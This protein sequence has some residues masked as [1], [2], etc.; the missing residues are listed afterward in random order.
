[1]LK[2]YLLAPEL[3]ECSKLDAGS[4]R[5]LL[6]LLEGIATADTFLIP[7]EDLL[8][9]IEDV[10]RI[11]A[12]MAPSVKERLLSD[13][14]ESRGG[15][16]GMDS[17]TSAR[18]ALKRLQRVNTANP[19][20]TV[21]CASELEACLLRRHL[22]TESTCALLGE[23]LKARASEPQGVELHTLPNEAAID[24]L[25]GKF[26]AR[27]EQLVIFDPYIGV[28]VLRSSAERR[29]LEIAMTKLLALASVRAHSARH[30][31]RVVVVLDRSKLNES[32]NRAKSKGGVGEFEDFLND[33]VSKCRATVASMAPASG[34]SSIGIEVSIR[35]A[36]RFQ[37]RGL[38]SSGR[39]W[40]IDH[41]LDDMGELLTALRQI[42]PTKCAARPYTTMCV[43][44]KQK[45]LQGIWTDSRTHD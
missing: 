13:L 33:S 43:E 18:S 23:V 15:I 22:S 27:G 19:H 3:L 25:L 1:M 7:R 24:A 20:D 5:D 9:F 14:A 26:F 37:E 2:T 38:K 17:P 6:Q 42:K 11:S 21:V 40:N 8:R 39:Y 29:F 16:L 12:P 10:G 32:F 35:V 44:A 45:V 34:S 41:Q 28:K 31:L 4:A 30:A 36:T